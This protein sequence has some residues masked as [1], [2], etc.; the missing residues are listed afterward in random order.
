MLW[1]SGPSATSSAVEP[2]RMPQK[3]QTK[4]QRSQTPSD[5][6]RQSATI[7]AGKRTVRQRPATWKHAKSLVCIQKARGSSPLSSTGQRPNRQGAPP[8]EQ[9]AKGDPRWATGHAASATAVLRLRVIGQLGCRWF[10]GV[11]DS[12][13]DLALTCV[14][15]VRRRPAQQDHPVNIPRFACRGSEQG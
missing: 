7:S 4:S 13:P 9:S 12:P 3:S 14:V 5:A 6:H 15:D 2:R 1:V 10:S 11:G 8:D